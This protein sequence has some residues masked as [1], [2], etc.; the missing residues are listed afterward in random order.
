MITKSN[1]SSCTKRSRTRSYMGSLP[2]S[3]SACVA[4]VPAPTGAVHG[5]DIRRREGVRHLVLLQVRGSVV[6]KKVACA[7]TFV[8][9]LGHNIGT[10][11]IASD[12]MS[13]T[14]RPRTSRHPLSGAVFPSPPSHR[15][16]ERARL[17]WPGP[18]ACR[19]G[20][21]E[22]ISRA[23]IR[24]RRACLVAP[25]PVAR[26]GSRASSGTSPSWIRRATSAPSSVSF[27]AT[28]HWGRTASWLCGRTRAG[29][30][31]VPGYSAIHR[32][33]RKLDP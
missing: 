5:E 3:R 18:F 1:A 17:K 21:E 7:R 29:V 10:S 22:R 16:D 32:P 20:S 25:Q 31:R 4:A 33:G 8:R 24:G 15:D 2:S 28:E 26:I 6:S 27:I 30:G 9:G 19:F 12:V 14:A 13:D 23:V 11:L